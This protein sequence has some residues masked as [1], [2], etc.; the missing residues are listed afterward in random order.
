MYRKDSTPHIYYLSPPVVY[1][2]SFTEVW[3][4]PKYTVN[5]IKDLE[6]DEMQFI[7]TKVGGSLLDFELDVN[8]ETRYSSYS[9]NKARG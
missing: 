1:Y 7:N 3:F 6:F 5:L 9:R 2:E 8:H 4:D